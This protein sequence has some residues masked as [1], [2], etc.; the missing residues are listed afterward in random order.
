MTPYL[1]AF[2]AGLAGSLH[3][4]GMCGGFVCVLGRDARGRSAT[5]RRH[6]VYNV[7]RVTSYCFVGALV[8]E[9]GMLL[10]GATA[11]GSP[12]VFAQRAL[13]LCSGALMVFFGLQFFGL[14]R[15]RPGRVGD[16]AAQFAGALRELLRAPGQAAPLAA[17]VL[18]GFLPCP[19]V[20]AF[21]AQAAG[22]GSALRGMLTMVAFGLGTFPMMLAVGVIGAVRRESAGSTSVVL[23]PQRRLAHALPNNG[24]RGGT[25]AWRRG[26]V[27]FAGALIVLLGVV[28]LARGVV[29]FGGHLHGL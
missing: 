13:A 22:C 9:L 17:G 2:V 5:L 21:A 27:R 18:N 23:P 12:V 20:Y 29:S 1:V 16:A 8:G 25:I 11:G 4:L 10:T 7:G 28:T 19:L 3:C 15:V 24:G 26:C 6:L 14:F